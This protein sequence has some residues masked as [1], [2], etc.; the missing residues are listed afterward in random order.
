MGGKQES[1]GIAGLSV[2]ISNESLLYEEQL[3]VAIGC[4]QSDE[5]SAWAQVLDEGQLDLA[6]AGGEDAQRQL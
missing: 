5:I 2:S 3:L 1:P 4:V 6:F